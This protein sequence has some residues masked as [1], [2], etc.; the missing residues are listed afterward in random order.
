[1]SLEEV[2]DNGMARWG[3]WPAWE[4]EQVVEKPRV[5]RQEEPRGSEERTIMTLGSI[6]VLLILSRT[7][8]GAS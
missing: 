7:L 1:M 5:D 3:A 6:L 4:K 8:P 2:K